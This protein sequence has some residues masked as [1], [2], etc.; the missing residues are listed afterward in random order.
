MADTLSFLDLPQEV[1]D[2]IFS[3]FEQNELIKI[4]LTCREFRRIISED[5]RWE[6]WYKAV[7]GS[8]PIGNAMKEY[9]ESYLQLQSKWRR[10]HPKIISRKEYSSY[11][12]AASFDDKYIVSTCGIGDGKVRVYD[13][14]DCLDEV[15][16]RHELSAHT[17]AGIHIALH[18]G[19][20]A[21]CG[22]DNVIR[23]FE[24]ESG[25]SLADIS[26]DSALYS[27]GINNDVVAATNA[28]GIVEVYSAV[29][30]KVC[31]VR[32]LAIWCN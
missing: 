3:F 16:L 14:A 29:D 5:R 20:A 13:L 7:F 32:Q 11:C 6:I 10:E 4:C 1:A 31:F 18:H 23:L 28:T 17:A 26:C 2:V 24:C 15:K 19:V 27:V 8:A 21:S 22:Y 25:K 9:C 30:F 12:M